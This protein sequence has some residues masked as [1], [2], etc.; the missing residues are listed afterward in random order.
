MDS[1]CT[2]HPSLWNNW[3]DFRFCRPGAR[4]WKFQPARL[5]GQPVA[6]ESILRFVFT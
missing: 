2:A 4:L 5:G 6:G 3:P 1:E